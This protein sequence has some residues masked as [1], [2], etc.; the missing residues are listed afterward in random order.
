LLGEEEGYEFIGRYIEKD[1]SGIGIVPEFN[2]DSEPEKRNTI[3]VTGNMQ[4]NKSQESR[5]MGNTIVDVDKAVVD[6]TFKASVTREKTRRRRCH[7]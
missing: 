1:I 6:T 5:Y 7:C 3:I 4:R 2:W